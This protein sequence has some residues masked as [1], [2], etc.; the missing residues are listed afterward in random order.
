MIW[1]VPGKVHLQVAHVVC[2]LHGNGFDF[3]QKCLVFLG[4][5]FRN[6]E[7]RPRIIELF[8]FFSQLLT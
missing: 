5:L 4:E 8:R 7:V 2:R 3:I 1:L 6:A